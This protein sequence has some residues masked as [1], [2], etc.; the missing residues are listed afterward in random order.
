MQ[1]V[2][3]FN[4]R[5]NHGEQLVGFKGLKIRAIAVWR[6]CQYE[7]REVRLDVRNSQV[8]KFIF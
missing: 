4:G 1:D 8:L 3:F 5:F 6:I 7:T 2:E